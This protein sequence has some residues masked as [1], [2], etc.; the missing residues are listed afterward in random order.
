MNRR[1]LSQHAPFSRVFP[2]SDEHLSARVARL[3]VLYED[4]AIELYGV[5]S[6]EI[7]VLDRASADIRRHYFPRRSIATLHE[8]SEAILHLDECPDF[9]PIKTSFSAGSQHK[10]DRAVTFLLRTDDPLGKVRKDVGGHF[11]LKAAYHAVRN[12]QSTSIGSIEASSEWRGDR[13]K[14]SKRKNCTSLARLLHVHSS[15]I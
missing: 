1:R 13:R 9:A 10:W 11:G 15:N 7:P 8:F 3:C 6:D 2:I 14:P 4:L 5:Q 12:F